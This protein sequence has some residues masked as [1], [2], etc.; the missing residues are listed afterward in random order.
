MR[1]RTMARYVF[2]ASTGYNNSTR[3][4]TVEIPDEELEGKTEEEKHNFIYDEYFQDWL[5]NNCDL[6]FYEED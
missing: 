4:E 2:Y 3:E 5:T 6:G 1:R